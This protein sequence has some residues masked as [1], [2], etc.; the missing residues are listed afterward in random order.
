MATAI[1]QQATSS[2]FGSL[3][4]MLDRVI[5]PEIRDELLTNGYNFAVSN[6]YLTVCLKR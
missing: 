1:F 3:T 5:P 6:P 4:G 2:V